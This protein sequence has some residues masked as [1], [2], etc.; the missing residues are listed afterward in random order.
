MRGWLARLAR[1]V[2]G[3]GQASA[4]S[5]SIRPLTIADC[6]GVAAIHAEGF[7]RGWPARE[8][9]GL[10]AD[11]AVAGDGLVDQGLGLIGFV[12]SRIAADE[13]EILSI[14]VRKSARGGGLATTLLAT[15]LAT[16]GARGARR[17]F[18]EVEEG[19][20]AALAL[21]RRFGF[22]EVGRRAAY[23]RQADGSPANALILRRDLS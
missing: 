19:N 3:K 2:S 6:A 14:A 8:V 15:H 17:L 1:F 18:L 11:R 22:A 23:F 13:A 5:T 4:L 10:I 9:E 21:Y 20:A 16:L 7:A 12:L